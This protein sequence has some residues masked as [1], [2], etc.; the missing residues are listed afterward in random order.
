M[1]SGKPAILECTD[2]NLGITSE[3]NDEYFNRFI[4]SAFG[5]RGVRAS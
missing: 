2:T 3:A 5:I 4:P 1:S